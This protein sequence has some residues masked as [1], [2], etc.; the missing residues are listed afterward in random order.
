[1]KTPAEIYKIA[2]LN[3]A[4]FAGELDLS[5]LN[6]S[7]NEIMSIFFN[8]IS[9]V[10]LWALFS[11][12]LLI[13]FAAIE[14]PADEFG[15]WSLVISSITL[16][17]Y[18]IGMDIY[19]PAVRALYEAKVRSDAASTIH[20]MASIYAF[21]FS[22]ICCVLLGVDQF[23]MYM[24]GT[25]PLL[26]VVL[27][28]FFEH[29]SAEAN[30]Q[31]N[32]MGYLKQANLVLLVRSSLPIIIF[33]L[34]CLAERNHLSSLLLS[35]IIGTA[36]A[37]LPAHYFLKLYL[38]DKFPSQD[39]SSLVPTSIKPLIHDLLKGCGLV[40]LSTIFLKAGQ[41]LDKQLLAT[42]ADLP[43]VGA[44]A[45]TMAAVSAIGSSIDAMLVSISISK[46]L[47]AEK[48]GD[49]AM[50]ISIHQQLRRNLQCL[51]SV[52]HIVVMVIFA[53]VKIYSNQTKFD[54]NLMEVAMLLGASLI[55]TYS[56]AD[57][58]L[59]FVLKKDKVSFWAAA[60]GLVA[61][62]VVIM[63]LKG[64]IGASSVACGVLVAA[65]CMWLVRKLAVDS[66][67]SNHVKKVLFR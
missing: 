41:T 50:Q 36:I 11:R 28:L 49:R 17:S 60:A 5:D 61:L 1:M 53:V 24:V 52:L 29:L 10:R 63:L 47:D 39:L 43:R 62:C 66:I 7:G 26:L 55:S 4:S 8:S 20:A 15:Q 46:L 21:N 22:L 27:L 44:Y 31:L 6:E 40:F 19:A 16:F 33:G 56:L 2:Q 67:C 37:L 3:C 32:L 23:K 65:I 54:F 64:L 38:N 30:R 35:Q 34:F 13:G 58:A 57:A 25:T 45:L 14:L 18:L 48:S 42:L 12:F 59:L 9:L 51:S